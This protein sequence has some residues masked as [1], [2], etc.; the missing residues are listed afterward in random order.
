[1]KIILILLD[2]KPIHMK[3]LFYLTQTKM[4]LNCRGKKEHINWDIFFLFYFRM[5]PVTPSLPVWDTFSLLVRA[6]SLTSACPRARVSS[7]PQLKNVTNVLRLPKMLLFAINLF[8][9]NINVSYKWL[10][11]FQ[12]LSF[13]ITNVYYN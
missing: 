8:F 7:S 6:A 3:L 10:V 11:I 1:M 5:P 4:T 2:V 12:D 9:N 13:Q